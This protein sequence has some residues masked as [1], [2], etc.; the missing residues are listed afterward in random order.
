MAAAPNATLGWVGSLSSLQGLKGY[1]FKASQN[2]S[3][4]FELSNPLLRAERYDFIEYNEDFVQSTQQAFYFIEDVIVD[5]EPIELGDWIVATHEG[6]L[7]GARSW[8]GPYTDVPVMGTDGQF[9]TSQYIDVGETPQLW[10]IKESTGEQI[11]IQGYIQS[12]QNNEFYFLNTLVA[13]TIP[14]EFIL[15][16]A[17]PNPFNPSTKIEFGLSDDADVNVKI[18]DISGREIAVLAQGQFSRGFH[19]VIWD[20]A[21]QPSGIYFVTI[22][23]QS[24]TQSQKLMLIK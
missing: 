4:N 22:S 24:E 3:F 21:N 5:G 20:A 7:V 8:N 13:T 1:W 12:W 16:S 6:E 15:L 9:E 19:N 2:I 11:Q 18:Y 23:T 14:D 17:Y 10:L